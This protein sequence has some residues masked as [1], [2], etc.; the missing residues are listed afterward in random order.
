[1]APFQPVRRI[2]SSLRVAFALPALALSIQA[3]ASCGAAFCVL[4]TG[5]DVVAAQTAPGHASV[6]LRYEFVPQ[7]ALYSGN[8]RIS[9]SAVEDEEAIETR[10]LNRNFS[11]AL[12]YALTANWG[13][14]VTLPLVSRAHSHIAEPDTDPHRES[15]N[16]SRFGDARVLGRYQAPLG[17][18]NV[19]GIQFGVKLPTGSHEVGNSA[20]DRAER[21]LQPGTG[22]TDAVLGVYYAY[23]PK[24][25]G[26]SWFAQAQ[27][28][29]AVATRD[30]Y[31]P[32]NQFSASLGFSAPLSERVSFLLQANGLVKRRDSGAQAEPEVSGGRYLFLS[33]GIGVTV[34]PSTR[35]YGYL[36]APLYRHVN[37]VQ[38]TADW[39]AVLGLTQ[40]F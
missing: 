32:G 15:W 23:R 12:D 36:Q 13:V 37:G 9:R 6:D 25:S 2:M 8:S 35:L 17:E 40:R 21:S 20:G 27:V 3:H 34:T 1:M 11:A 39:S 7:K 33:P 5:W 16:F 18:T 19:G 28:Q 29:A 24:F 4:N 30:H 31:R 38:L 14:M 26:L 22:S 10:T